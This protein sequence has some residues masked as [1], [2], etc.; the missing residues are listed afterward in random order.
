RERLEKLGITPLRAC[1]RGIAAGAQHK[2]RTGSVVAPR[3][4]V[5]TLE[6]GVEVRLAVW[7]PN[8]RCAEL[9]PGQLQQL[10]DLGLD[11]VA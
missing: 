6:D 11:W 7:L 10:A 3:A 5:E 2:A 4:H 9:T 8:S 1:E